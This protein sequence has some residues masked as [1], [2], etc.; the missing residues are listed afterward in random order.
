MPD[1]TSNIAV[2][3][4]LCSQEVLA[5]PSQNPLI[6]A[7][8]D[9]TAHQ[10]QTDVLMEE[11]MQLIA[12]LKSRVAVDTNTRAA[13]YSPGFSSDNSDVYMLR[14]AELLELQGVQIKILGELVEYLALRLKTQTPVTSADRRPITIDQLVALLDELPPET[15]VDKVLYLAIRKVEQ[16]HRIS[17]S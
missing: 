6:E 12:V 15:E 7:E 16:F 11:T 10:L 13:I 9:I 4:N 3:A 1:D 8:A 5:S 17:G 2:D 14:S